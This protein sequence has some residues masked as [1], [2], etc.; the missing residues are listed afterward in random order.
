MIGSKSKPMRTLP[1][2]KYSP[3]GNMT[4]LA[5]D[6]SLS[7]GERA[8]CAGML[9]RPDHLGAEQ[10]GYVDLHSDPPRLE[11]MGG[12]FCVN[13]CRALA[14]LLHAEQRLSLPVPPEGFACPDPSPDPDWRYGL[15]RCSGAPG[16][17][18]VR[19]R[20]MLGA[21]AGPGETREAG[22]CLRLP[23]PPSVEP[24]AEGIHLVR[25]PGISHLILNTVSHP[26]PEDWRGASA[27]LR[28][29]FNLEGEDAAG[30]LWLKTGGTDNDHVL[31]MPVVWVRA[32]DTAQ[33]ESACGS[34]SLACAVYLLRNRARSGVQDGGRVSIRQPGGET[35]DIAVCGQD[36]DIQVWIS[37]RVT[38]VA[39]G[40]AFVAL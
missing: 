29:G 14:A 34:G 38:C 5:P 21:S 37:G 40:E 4:I 28:R 23:A 18:A 35:L 25:L 3:S 32:T 20:M 24:L 33:R 11:M 17:L 9:M 26:V 13:A 12:E 15:V 8:A 1:F 7:P 6:M 19:A 2:F 31:L 27:A 10:V 22:V 36:K 39:R 30:C 16:N